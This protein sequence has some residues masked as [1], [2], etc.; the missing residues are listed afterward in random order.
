VMIEER[1]DYKTYQRCHDDTCQ[2][3]VQRRIRIRRR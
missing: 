1:E 2:H 3:T